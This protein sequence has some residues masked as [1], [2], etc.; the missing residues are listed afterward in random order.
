MNP[1]AIIVGRINTTT[2]E[3]VWY[4]VVRVV[5]TIVCKESV[6]KER[7]RERDLGTKPLSVVT[8]DWRRHR[9]RGRCL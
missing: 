4:V 6:C 3:T 2:E 9:A 8:V 7:E 1:N 5:V